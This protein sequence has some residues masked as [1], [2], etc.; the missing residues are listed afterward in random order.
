MQLIDLTGWGR[1]LLAA[2]IALLAAIVVHR[3][4]RAI[5]LR[6]VRFSVV[7]D[8]V[9]RAIDRPASFALP[10]AA[11]QVVWHGAPDTLPL[12][13]G[14]RHINA[15][16]LIAALTWLAI[17]AVRGL[18]NGVI[19][20]HPADV[21]DNLQ[22]RRIHT[23]TRV[24]SRTVMGA[25]VV[26]GFA[27]MLMTFPGAR[28]L[29]ASLLAS[30]GV[31][32]LVVGIAARP[33]FSNLIA[34]LQIALSQPI[35]LDDVLII[36]GEWG[37]VEEITGNYVVLCIWDQRRMI[38]PL[39]WFIENPFQNWTRTSAEIIGTVTLWVDYTMPIDALRPVAQQ[40]SE[41]SPDWDGRLCKLQ[42]TE[43]GE[44]AMQLRLMLTSADSGRNWD[45]RCTVREALVDYIRREHPDALPRLR[46]VVDGDARAAPGPAM[47]T[48]GT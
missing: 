47:N 38:I 35:R 14:L 18:A 24:L 41:A 27:M 39:Q 16:L 40:A 15:L 11:L 13:G 42:L 3:I 5:V 26:A 7:L 2:L 46:A 23:Q 33:V 48:P 36:Q 9:V 6:V 17:R 28:Q 30:A 10:L 19:R 44:H 31:A 32:G 29:G 21:A 4:G 1:P 8:S 12:I 22:A 20:L 25:L 43:A 34:G 45:L 37:R